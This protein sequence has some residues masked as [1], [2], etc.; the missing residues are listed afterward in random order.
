MA[1]VLRSPLFSKQMEHSC[2]A[3]WLLTS[4][5]GFQGVFDD[6]GSGFGFS[7]PRFKLFG[8]RMVG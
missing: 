5:F 2:S 4:R 1:M 6:Y 3:A 8:F 7:A